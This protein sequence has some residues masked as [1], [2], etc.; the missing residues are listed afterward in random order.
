MRDMKQVFKFCKEEGISSDPLRCK[1]QSFP[2]EIWFA[3]RNRLEMRKYS[4]SPSENCQ[5]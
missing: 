4:L 5:L 3:V 1:D 2:K